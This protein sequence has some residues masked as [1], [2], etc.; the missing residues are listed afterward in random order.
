MHVLPGAEGLHQRRVAGKMG[1]QPQL[2]LAVVR[3]QQHPALPGQ[4]GP[5]DLL[6]L[7]GADGDVLQIRLGGGN[8]PG[9]GGHLVKGGMHPALCVGQAKKAL[10]IG[11]VQ[12]GQLAVSQKR[13]DDFRGNVPQALQHL[14]GGGIAP[15]GLFAVGQLQ[16]VEEHLAQLLGAVQVEGGGVAG[17]KHLLLCFFNILHIA[18]AQF[19]QEGGV[20]RE[21]RLLHAEQGDGQ[22][23]LHLFHQGQH[24]VLLHPAP[25]PQGQAHQR[26]GVRR[27]AGA[28]GGQAVAFFLGV[29]QIRPQ[30]GVPLEAF[31]QGQALAAEGVEQALAVMHQGGGGTQFRGQHSQ[32]LG[33]VGSQAEQIAPHGHQTAVPRAVRH[34]H[35]R[36]VHIDRQG[37]GR[38]AQPG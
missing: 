14:G 24:A 36:I 16:L 19:P 17:G 26:P 15:L 25:L 34:G 2:N 21:A 23:Q 28:Q 33:G 27:H 3:V 8:A 32:Q 35:R 29:E 13:I 37:A 10:H 6:A 38:A 20:H 9:G 7:L 30:H 31:R 1:H 18:L 11:G 5:A 4:E 22:G 12:L